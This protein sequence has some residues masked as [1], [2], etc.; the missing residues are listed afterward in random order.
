MESIKANDDVIRSLN[1][2]CKNYDAILKTLV[3]TKN[4]LAHINQE[5]SIKHNKIVKDLESIKDRLSRDIIKE[6]EYWPIYTEWLKAVPGIGSFVS[7]NLVLLYYY[8]FVAICSDCGTDVIKKENGEGNTF[9]CPTCN[10][11]IKGDG[12]LK[13]RIDTSKDFSNVSKW[14]AYLGEHVIDGKMPKRK[15]G[16]ASNWSAKGRQ[17]A[18]Q[19]GES[20][21][22]QAL[23]HPYKNHLLEVKSKL[24]TVYPEKSKGHRHSMAKM[25]AVKLFLSHFWHVAREMDGKSTRG[26]YADVILEHTG[27][28]PPYYWKDDKNIPI[29]EVEEELI[30]VAK[31]KR[32]AVKKVKAVSEV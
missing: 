32:K 31:P 11:S 9:F 25:R 21:N 30:E 15:A 27:I 5:E 28:I 7:G 13:T 18:F 20:F 26:V 3:A 10:R 1:Y 22:K 17:V 23:E 6:L 4:R 8:K 24:E 12:I 14:W 19:I 2:Y 16:V 29:I